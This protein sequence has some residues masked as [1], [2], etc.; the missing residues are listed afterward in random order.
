MIQE[1]LQYGAN[2]SK[3]RPKNNANKDFSLK[4]MKING[5]KVRVQL[6][7]GQNGDPESTFSPLFTRHTAGCIIV[8]N[9]MNSK[10]VKK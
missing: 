9:A 8:C 5:E 4:I 3:A 6:W 7:D 2:P 10:S 1:F